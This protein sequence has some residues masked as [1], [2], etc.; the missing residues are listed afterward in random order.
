M[1]TNH[2]TPSARAR[3]HLARRRSLP[4]SGV[5]RRT[6]LKAL[7]LA[8][9]AA[10]LPSLAP[11]RVHAAPGNPTRVLLLVTG[12]GTVYD[13]WKMRPGN[14][15]EDSDWEF[16]L[17][18]LDQSEFSPI[19]EPFHGVR[20]HLLVLDG[21]AAGQVGT[22][23]INEH[24]AGHVACLTGTVAQAVQD[25]L[26]IST[27]PSI[28]Q[29]IGKAIATAG[30]YPTLEYTV[31]GWPVCF[32][33]FGQSIPYEIDVYAAYERLFPGGQNPN[34]IPT[35]ADTI[36]AAQPSVLDL[37]GDRYDALAPKLS[38]ED[39]QKLEQHRDLVRGLE[40]QLEALA[41]IE[42][43]A[44]APPGG[45]PDWATAEYPLAYISAYVD[46]IKIAL[47]CRLSPV[48]T[49]R[50]ETMFNE[51]IGA[52]AG[53]LHN[54]WAHKAE[55]D[56]EAATVMSNYH[57]FHAQWISQLI[58]ELAATPDAGGSLLDDTVVVWT[59]ELSTGSHDFKRFP[60]LV[61]G[62]GA[63]FSLGRWVRWAPKDTLQGTWGTHEI[64]PSHNRWLVSLAR[65]L[66]VDVDQVGVATL[67]RAGGGTI[68][69][70]GELDRLRR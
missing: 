44:P 21:L 66:G 17:G 39:R 33:E 22:A 60:I 13:S 25:S 5:G 63:H 46:I 12:H 38:G 6:L 47:S 43:D 49:L 8:G 57:R 68:D 15:G 67:P 48:I 61:A 32:D 11:R 64:G 31:G 30:Q 37:V 41:G 51:T 59:N 26:A 69:C 58:A 18:A 23:G 53:D 42:C 54:D 28:D 52:P 16:E 7:G 9:A 45:F 24:E 27:G 55:E 36:R 29:I 1:S 2:S 62:G 50:A 35:E 56:P 70:T 40:L 34:P 4:S 65:A 3:A 19:L 20:D 14:L 10:F